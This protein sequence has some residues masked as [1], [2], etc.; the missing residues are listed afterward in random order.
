[1]FFYFWDPR[2]EE[3][4][5]QEVP[6]SSLLAIDAPATGSGSYIQ[7]QTSLQSAA[8]YNISG[9][10][11]V[12]TSFQLQGTN[13]LF[14]T[15]SDVYGN[16]RVLQNN[17]TTLQDGMYINYNSTGGAAADLKFYANGTS[18]RMRILASNGNVGIGLA[19]PGYKLHV[20][21]DIY[22]NGGWL[23]TSGN[24]GWYSESWG[25]GWHMADG[26]WIRSYGSKNVYIDQLIFAEFPI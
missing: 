9:S 11:N 23:R 10:G 24:E 5:G 7:N 20:T 19:G 14:N 13:V 8:N 17:S 3:V 25:G 16:I 22:A 12:Q 6:L 1:M 26:A 21:G 18:E 2:F 15:G 4:S